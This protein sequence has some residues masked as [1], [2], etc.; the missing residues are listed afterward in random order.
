MNR[1]RLL[2]AAVCCAAVVLVQPGSAQTLPYLLFERYVDALR[3]QTGIP[4][5]SAAIIRDGRTEW[6][7]GLGR[8][9]VE[10]GIAALPD[11]P[12]PVA[13]LTQTVA[14][15]HLLRC[16][17]A[18]Q[19]DSFSDPIGKWVP[20][21]PV[22]G[23]NL[24][25]VSAHATN[26]APGVF[27]FDA[28][29]FAALTTVAEFC[30]SESY[31]AIIAREI[32]DR[33]GMASSVPGTDLGTPDSPARAL[34]TP[35]R[36]AHY[37]DVLQRTAVPYRLSGSG[38]AVRADFPVMGLSAS[39]GLISTVR[40]LARFLSAIDSGVLLHPASVKLISTPA[41]F[42]AGPIP[43]AFGWFAQDVDGQRLVWQFGHHPDAYSSLIVRVPGK[44]LTLIMLANSGGLASG[45]NL[46][47]GDIT[48][49][50]FVRIFQRLFL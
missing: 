14:I 1:L 47:R 34:F 19:I 9:D 18:R 24:R 10:R 50:P 37:G 26:G 43:A 21:F 5:L 6:E 8:Q 16:A 13:G 20:T 17:E 46:E 12:Y 3:V 30:G 36:L 44:G 27:R 22:A 29:R 35:S 48:A 40:D 2:A 15:T 28:G 4:G 32:L 41:E 33:L 38:Q 11:T 39:T 7:Q 49:S 42:G 31:A 25:H 45:V 23:A